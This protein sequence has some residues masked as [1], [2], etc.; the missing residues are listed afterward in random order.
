MAK[1]VDPLAAKAAKQKKIA[2][3]GFVLLILVMAVQGPKTLKMI[4]GPGAPQ[5]APAI[6]TPTPVPGTTPAPG[7]PTGGTAAAA[8]GDV[9]E[10][11]SVADSDPAPAAEQ[12][13]LATFE[14][15]ASKDP[16]AQQAIA[17][18]A[19]ATPPAAPATGLP[20]TPDPAAPSTGASSGGG[21]TETPPSDTGFTTGGTTP[22]EP[23]V[24]TAT[25]TSI[26]VNG[27]AEDVEPEANFPA[28]EPTFVLVSIAKD[29]KSVQVGIAG[30][31]YADGGA[32][33][34]LAF[35]KKVTLQNTADGSRY[36]LELRSIKGFPIPKKK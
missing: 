16:F 29:G 19:T 33:L 26:A 13:Q 14:R 9:V 15:F 8:P 23:S 17:P 1:R 21:S 35:G 3:G 2:I 36:E 24:P 25:A 5:A 31:S 22:S 7:V 32:T 20:V 11:T 30:G 18:A 28:A 12:G 6:A 4:K 34:K 27:A 10:L